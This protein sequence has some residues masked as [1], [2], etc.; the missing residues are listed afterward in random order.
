MLPERA[1]FDVVD[2][3]HGREIHVGLAFSLDDI[4]FGDATGIW[5]LWQRAFFWQRLLWPS[6]CGLCQ[7]SCTQYIRDERVVVQ[8][9]DPV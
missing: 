7:L 8:T 2:E 1:P 9:P 6:H 5:S 4:G 3:P